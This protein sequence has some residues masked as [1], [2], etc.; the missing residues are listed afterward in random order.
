MACVVRPPPRTLLDQDDLQPLLS[1]PGLSSEAEL[2]ADPS[3]Q[4]SGGEGGKGGGGNETTPDRPASRCLRGAT[5]PL[6][7]ARPWK[8]PSG[9]STRTAAASSPRPGFP[10]ASEKW[11][12]SENSR[13]RRWTRWVAPEADPRARRPM[14][15]PYPARGA[16]HRIARRRYYPRGVIST[17][18]GHPCEGVPSGALGSEI[19]SSCPVSHDSAKG[20][21]GRY[22]LDAPPRVSPPRARRGNSSGACGERPKKDAF[23]GLDHRAPPRVRLTMAAGFP[24]SNAEHP[25]TTAPAVTPSR[26]SRGRAGGLA[27]GPRSSGVSLRAQAPAYASSIPRPEIPSDRP[28][29]RLDSGLAL[30]RGRGRWRSFGGGQRDTASWAKTMV[31]VHWRPQRRWCRGS[32]P[33]LTAE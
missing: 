17:P 21:G 25:W 23:G 32:G 16:P 27:G 1:S 6:R 26:L 10:R 14:G 3:A 28:A 2:A 5:V 19:A 18:V 11:A 12:F 8:T 9:I 24:P 7:W 4:V 29:S 20:R 22:C 13:R 15:L 30:P 33:M 31:S